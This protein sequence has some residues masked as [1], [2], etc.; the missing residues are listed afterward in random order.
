MP[1]LRRLSGWLRIW[2][3]P[4]YAP[5]P[6]EPDFPRLAQMRGHRERSG[7][8]FSYVSIEEL[9]RSTRN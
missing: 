2:R 5:L 8:L 1:V 6:R 7:S 4:P 9:H 3:S